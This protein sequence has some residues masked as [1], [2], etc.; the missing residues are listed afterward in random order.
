LPLDLIG[1]PNIDM[2]PGCERRKVPALGIDELERGDIGGFA[3]DCSNPEIEG[4]ILRPLLH[5]DPHH[6]HGR[7][8]RPR[9]YQ[10]KRYFFTILIQKN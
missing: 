4:S 5:D 3:P 6:V 7:S 10:Y 8:I 9:Q 1:D 2:R